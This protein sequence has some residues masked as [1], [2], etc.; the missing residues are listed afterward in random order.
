MSTAKDHNNKWERLEARIRPEQKRLFKRAADLSG[1]SLTDFIVSTLQKAAT[2]MV[3]KQEIINLSLQDQEIFAQY[4]IDS[5]E[6]NNHL[7]QAAQ[8]Y[9]KRNQ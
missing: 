9:K 6:P 8:D 2:D 3:E 5:P 1:Q 4:L 7:K